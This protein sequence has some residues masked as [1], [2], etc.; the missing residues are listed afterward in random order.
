MIYAMW[1]RKVA[2]G[3]YLAFGVGLLLWI[4]PQEVLDRYPLLRIGLGV[5]A[6]LCIFGA[7]YEWW[8]RKDD[9]PRSAQRELSGEQMRQIQAHLS[10]WPAYK[11]NEAHKRNLIN[12]WAS[13]LAPDGRQYARQ[14]AMALNADG[15]GVWSDSDVLDFTH[16]SEPKFRA[17]HDANITVFGEDI[18]S[19]AGAPLHQVLVEAFRAAQVD[20]TPCIDV[21][22]LGG[23]IGIVIGKGTNPRQVGQVTSTSA[24]ASIGTMFDREIVQLST[25]VE[26]G[27][28]SV[29]LIKQER[30]PRIRID[31]SYTWSHV[32]PQSADPQMHIRNAGD[33]EAKRVHVRP[34]HIQFGARCLPRRIVFCPIDVLGIT[35]PDQTK[36]LFPAFH[37]SHLL[38]N[39]KASCGIAGF[40]F[41]SYF[42]QTDATVSPAPGA[43]PWIITKVSD[44]VQPNGPRLYRSSRRPLIKC[45]HSVPEIAEGWVP[46]RVVY[47]DDYNRR[48]AAR[49]KL[50]FTI[51]GLALATARIELVSDGEP[52]MPSAPHS[53]ALALRSASC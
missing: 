9:A 12:V 34:I 38:E 17:M 28:S 7:A 6:A 52:T 41:D 16:E 51:M 23:V 46:I 31:Y 8:W 13:P 18:A 32:G 27:R 40:L 30:R 45:V 44:S 14:I 49:F 48:Y 33:D 5:V 11:P 3:V 42:A 29:G 4:I 15:H 36:V 21:N 50:S 39:F 1:K 37:G 25:P 10:A 26:R 47:F 43:E 22:Q 20:V 53:S 19:H 2:A 35:G 24:Q